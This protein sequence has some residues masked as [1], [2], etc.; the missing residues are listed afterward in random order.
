MKPVK[1]TENQIMMEQYIYYYE[2]FPIIK[3][4]ILYKSRE[5]QS[6]T[7]SPYAIFKYLLEKELKIFIKILSDKYKTTD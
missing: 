2:S 4:S 5:G 1:S 6:L 3:K 7:D